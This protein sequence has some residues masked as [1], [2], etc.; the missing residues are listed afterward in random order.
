MSFSRPNEVVDTIKQPIPLLDLHKSVIE[1]GC[2]LQVLRN[3]RGLDIDRMHEIQNALDRLIHV[4][5]WKV[6][7]VGSLESELAGIRFLPKLDTRFMSYIA[8]CYEVW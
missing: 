5:C 8:D 6:E 3:G 7:L 4:T 2:I 1:S